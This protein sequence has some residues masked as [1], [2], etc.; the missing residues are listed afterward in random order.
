MNQTLTFKY[1][2]GMYWLFGSFFGGVLLWIITYL[3]FLTTIYYLYALAVIWIGLSVAYQLTTKVELSEGK[4]LLVNPYW[5]RELIELKEI[6][7]VTFAKVFRTE[8]QLS[9]YGQTP[10]R[11]NMPVFILL[12]PAELSSSKLS[13]LLSEI[14]KANPDVLFPDSTKKYLLEHYM[15]KV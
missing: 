11:R 15:V 6:Q 1:Y 3:T 13:M 2:L 14:Q 5:K 8:D 4:I 9:L 7:K 10:L 12:R